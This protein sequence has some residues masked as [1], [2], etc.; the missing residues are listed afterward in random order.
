MLSSP[1]S[2]NRPRDGCQHFDGPRNYFDPSRAAEKID[3]KFSH[4]DAKCGGAIE[5]NLE[6]FLQ[7]YQTTCDK[8]CIPREYHVKFMGALFKGAAKTFFL[9]KIM[10]V[11]DDPDVASRM[12]RDKYKTLD[13][14]A[15]LSELY[16]SL[17]YSDVKTDDLTRAEALDLMTTKLLNWQEQLG[18]PCA[19]PILYKD[20]IIQAASG[21]KFSSVYR[22][23][24]LWTPIKLCSV[25]IWASLT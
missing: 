24:R 15:R 1:H 23:I 5:E 11:T 21:E 8:Y 9:A 22:S 17:K 12:L 18:A 13:R 16:N 20:R 19:H 2:P 25:Y 6:H 3:K 10:R 7:E 4:N 14:H